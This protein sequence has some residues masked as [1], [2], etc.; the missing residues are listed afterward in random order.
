MWLLQKLPCGFKLIKKL[1][2]GRRTNTRI[3]PQ[4]RSQYTRSFVVVSGLFV[5][6]RRERLLTV[7]NGS[8]VA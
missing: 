8:S 4:R 3:S 2:P 7:D 1:N 6:W 5:I